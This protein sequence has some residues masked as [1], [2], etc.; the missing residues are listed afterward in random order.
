[1]EAKD[2]M[3]SA[4]ATSNIATHPLHTQAPV[5]WMSFRCHMGEDTHIPGANKMAGYE[6]F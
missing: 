4:E 2:K 1:M 6:D 5:Q 3:Q